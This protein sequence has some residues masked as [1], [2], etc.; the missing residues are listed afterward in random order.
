MTRVFLAYAS[1]TLDGSQTLFALW[2]SKPDIRGAIEVD[3][4]LLGGNSGR[5]DLVKDQVG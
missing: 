5:S 2:T 1:T 4:V 3:L